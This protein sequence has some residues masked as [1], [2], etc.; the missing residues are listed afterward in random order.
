MTTT[1]RMGAEQVPGWASVCRTRSEVGSVLDGGAP[2]FV[3][4]QIVGSKVCGI[5]PELADE[6]DQIGDHVLVEADGARGRSLKAPAAHEPVIP[7]RADVVVV[8]SGLDAIGRSIASAAH[9]PHLVAALLGR[10]VED[11]VRPVDVAR[12]LADPNGG[13]KGVPEAAR[14]VVALTKSGGGPEN[15]AEV[16]AALGTSLVERVVVVDTLDE[17]S[18]GGRARRL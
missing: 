4:A 13:C 11:V 18:R 7:S 1:T 5:A 10:Q 17:T 14:V 6:L 2:A 12:V 8:V 15:A 9:R 16:A 3:V